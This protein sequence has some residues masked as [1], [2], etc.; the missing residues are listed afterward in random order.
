LNS[1]KTAFLPVPEEE[2]TL[3]LSIA[4]TLSNLGGSVFV[5]YYDEVMSYKGAEKP[6]SFLGAGDNVGMFG[7]SIPATSAFYRVD[8]RVD[9]GNEMEFR[10]LRVEVPEPTTAMLMAFGL[11]LVVYSNRRR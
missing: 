6:L 7:L 4:D 5:L 10:N 8:I 3:T 9:N 11:G 2:A 1:A